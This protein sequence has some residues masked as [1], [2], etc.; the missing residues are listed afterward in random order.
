[1]TLFVGRQKPPAP[2]VMLF[3]SEQQ[4]PQVV[5]LSLYFTIH[6]NFAIYEHAIREIVSS[7]TQK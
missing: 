4:F 5:R 7:G 3:P 1:M 2:G 6:H